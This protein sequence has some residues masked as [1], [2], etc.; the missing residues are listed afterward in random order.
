MFS[1]NLIFPEK[2]MQPV[3]F[4]ISVWELTSEILNVIW[5]V[6]IYFKPI[7]SIDIVMTNS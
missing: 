7:Y 4:I 3:S 2:I 6:L 1:D 5:S